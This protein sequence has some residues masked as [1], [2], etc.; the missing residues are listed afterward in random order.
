MIAVFCFHI[1]QIVCFISTE[2][3][4]PLRDASLKKICSRNLKVSKIIDLKIL[5]SWIKKAS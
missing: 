1:P 3:C 4:T 5:E 2:E